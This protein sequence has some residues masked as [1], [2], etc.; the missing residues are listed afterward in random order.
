MG[1]DRKDGLPKPEAESEGEKA[2]AE[3]G[4]SAPAG[5]AEREA[6]LSDKARVIL[7]MVRREESRSTDGVA[8]WQPGRAANLARM[9][10]RSFYR[11]V[12]ELEDSG[13]VQRTRITQPGQLALVEA[14]KAEKAT[15]EAFE[16]VG[17]PT[18]EEI[19]LKEENEGPDGLLT[20]LGETRKLFGDVEAAKLSSVVPVDVLGWNMAEIKRNGSYFKAEEAGRAPGSD[21]PRWAFHC[22]ES[23]DALS[24]I[25]SPYETLGMLRQRWEIMKHVRAD[26]DGYL[27]A[28]SWARS[29][30]AALL[31]EEV[32]PDAEQNLP[33]DPYSWLLR[34]DWMVFRLVTH[35]KPAGEI[36]KDD[37]GWWFWVLYEKDHA[38]FGEPAD[39]RTEWWKRI[40]VANPIWKKAPNEEFDEASWNV[41]DLARNVPWPGN[42]W[43]VL[44]I[45]KVRQWNERQRVRVEN[46][47]QAGKGQPAQGKADAGSFVSLADGFEMGD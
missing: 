23:L 15:A 29:Q 39:E 47:R 12:E 10:R 43:G 24:L 3:A 17:A 45:G 19:A 4:R 31:P 25:W 8:R 28:R 36:A 27:D 11:A 1:S 20:P 40:D 16:A 33:E 5:G 7:A 38:R 42:H 32:M 26:R 35:W 41:Q 9:S 21:L 2:K 46:P 6:S 44:D 22:G 18:M 14:S 30:G 13:L 37:A 34:E